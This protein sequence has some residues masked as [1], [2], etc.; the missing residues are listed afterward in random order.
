M[1]YLLLLV[2]DGMKNLV[3]M[4]SVIMSSSHTLEFSGRMTKILILFK[5]FYQGKTYKEHEQ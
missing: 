5:G 3:N 4:L 1:N 2:Q